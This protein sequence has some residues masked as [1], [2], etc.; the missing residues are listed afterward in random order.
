[1]LA[2]GPPMGMP[3][4][5]PMHF[6]SS[7]GQ[8]HMP[9][10]M[11]VP[12]PP[13]PA[14]MGMTMPHVVPPVPVAP[15]A[16]T[17]PSSPAVISVAID[18]LPFRYQLS[19][20]DVRETFQRWGSVLSVQVHQGG[21]RD[22]A[23]V[24]F[25]D[26]VDAGDAQ[27]QLSGQSCNFEGA[28]GTLVVVLGGPEQLARPAQFNHVPVRIPGAQT[29]PAPALPAS[30]P[31]GMP[32]PA[33]AGPVPQQPPA[34][35]LPGLQTSGAPAGPSG[36]MPKNGSG[37]ESPGQLGKGPGKGFAPP[38]AAPAPARPVWC[39][40][41]VVEAEALHPEFP[42]ISRIVGEG[43]ANV[44]HIRSQTK[45]NAVLRGKGSGTL[46]PET[47]QEL[48]E[49]L[50]LWLTADSAENG[51]TGLE[52]TQDLL[53]SIY[54]GHQQWCE[55]NG[56][57][58][59]PSLKPKVFEN[60][61]ILPSAA[62]PGAAAAQSQGAPAPVVLQPGAQGHQGNFG[63]CKG[64]PPGPMPGGKGFGPYSYK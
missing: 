13:P 8:M 14:H 48:P 16:P 31:A 12:M 19:E 32:A 45:C 9:P 63:P 49:N 28:T 60:P 39:C 25:A 55:Q 34:A 56:M 29:V 57:M 61:E 53:K 47:G 52:M 20:A 30:A 64:A 3:N 21:H 6:M 1:M 33:L 11:M 17:A 38:P 40:K 54:E 7:P 26:Q 4:G 35:A 51:K 42:T 59:P 62:G 44:E 37:P 46:E 22:V 27:R 2:H 5:P 23:V 36:A 24:H 41:I 18:N 15:T 10:H 50:F 58:H 43:G